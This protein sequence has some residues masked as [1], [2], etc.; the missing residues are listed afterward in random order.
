MFAAMDSNGTGTTGKDRGFT[1]VELL[2]VIVILGVLAAVTVFA[3]RGITDK[4][5]DNAMAADE[6]IVVK[7]EEA[8]QALHGTYVSEAG[9]VTA[10]LLTE[11]STLHDVNVLGGGT[12]YQ[13]VAASGGSVAT[14]VAATTTVAPSSWPDGDVVNTTFA[15]FVVEQYGNGPEIALLLG[16]DSMIQ[17]DWQDFTSNNP[18]LAGWTLYNVIDPGLDTAAELLAARAEADFTLYAWNESLEGQSAWS[19]LKPA[20]GGIWTAQAN[21]AAT[22]WSW[23]YAPG[24]TISDF[25]NFLATSRNDGAIV[26]Y[27]VTMSGGYSGWA[28]T[29]STADPVAVLVGTPSMRAGYESWLQDLDNL[30]FNQPFIYVQDADLD[31]TAEIEALDSITSETIFL[32]ADLWNLYEDEHVGSTGSSVQP[33]S[34]NDLEYIYPF[35]SGPID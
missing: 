11:Q 29:E 15:G 17:D 10:G 31:T 5:T 32:P 6:K 18:A 24:Y 12:D 26:G 20:E 21:H 13:I 1:L 34:V 25:A 9:L 2:I 14:T 30:N 4:G 28:S 16:R 23:M 27:S 7:A 33:W 35:V 19:I 8:H 22:Y 3:V